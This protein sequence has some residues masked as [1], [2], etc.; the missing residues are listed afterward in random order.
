MKKTLKKVISLVLVLVMLMS[1]VAVCAA[2]EGTT[3]EM[4]APVENSTFFSIFLEFFTE[5]Y[6]LLKYLFHD[7]WLGKPPV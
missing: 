1:V 6:G 4:P 2:A 3:A 5:F 7:L